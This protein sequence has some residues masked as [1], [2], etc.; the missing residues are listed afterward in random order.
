MSTGAA[1]KG[2]KRKVRNLRG[3]VF[4]VYSKRERRWVWAFDKR[5]RGV[6]KTE[7]GFATRKEAEDAAAALRVAARNRAYGFAPEAEPVTLRQLVAERVKDLDILRNRNDRRAKN[8]LEAFAARFPAAQVVT[9]ITTADLIAYKRDRVR[10]SALRANSLNRELEFIAGL[11]TRAGDYFPALANWKHP[12]LPYEKPTKR[13]RPVAGNE[14]ALFLSALREPLLAR[15][16]ELSRRARVI[17]ADLWEFALQTGMRRNEMR[18]MEKSWVD[19]EAR[20]V[21]LPQHAVKTREPRPVPLNAVALAILRRRV[22][23]SPHP[24]YV[25]TNAEGTNMIGEFQMYRHFRNAAKRAGVPYGRKVEGGFTLHDARHTV[26][27]RMGERKVGL[28]VVGAVLGHSAETMTL[29]YQV[30]TREALQEAVDVLLD[31]EAEEISRP[32]VGAAP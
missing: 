30:A 8:V 32:P 12:R 19:F 10:K 21:N 1:K 25:F 31:E 7:S 23:E 9:D 16:R 3:G 28:K 4:E 17:A 11:F 15:E 29:R 20:V 14:S 2:P 27:T 5:V 18:R 13:K 24:R 26:A 22:T 6:R